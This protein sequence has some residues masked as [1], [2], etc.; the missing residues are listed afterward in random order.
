M[1]GC[2]EQSKYFKIAQIVEVAHSQNILVLQICIQ[3]C[4]TTKLSIMAYMLQ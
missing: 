1:G 3:L 4:T 2:K